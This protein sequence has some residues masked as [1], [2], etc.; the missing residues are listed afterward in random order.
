[1]ARERFYQ[2]GFTFAL[3][4]LLV[5]TGTLGSE[6]QAISSQSSEI[7]AFQPITDIP[8]IDLSDPHRFSLGGNPWYPIGYYPSVAALTIDQTDYE[9]YYKNLIDLLAANGLNYFRNVFTM[10]QPYAEAMAPYVRTGPGTAADGRAKF[11][12]GQFN[13]AYF[14]YWRNVATYAQSKGVVVQLTIFDNWHNKA[15]VVEDNGDSQHE[16]G[17]K[18]DFYSGAN[19]V[20]GVDT[21]NLGDWTNPAHAVYPV[22]Q[23]LIRKVVDELGDLPNIVYEISNENYASASW[24]LQLADYLSDYEASKGYGSHLVMPR[25]LPNHDAAGGKGNDPSTTHSEMVSRYGRNQP[26]IADNDGGGNVSADGRRNKAWAALTAGGHIDYF[27][28]A[29]YQ[30]SVLN[31]ADVANGMRYL[32]L[33]GS[34]LDTYQVELRGMVPSDSLVSAGW[35]YAAAGDRYIVYLISGGSTTISGLPGSYSAIW[36]DPRTGISSPAAGGP[37][38]TAP[39]SQDWVLYVWAS[40]ATPM[41]TVTATATQTDTPVPTATP[42]ASH[43]PAPTQTNTQTP[44]PTN[45]PTATPSETPTPLP[46]RTLTPLPTSTQVPSPTAVPTDTPT[47][48]LTRT[49]TAIPTNTPTATASLTPTSLPTKTPTATSTPTI[50]PT[51]TATAT[52]APIPGDINLDGRVDVLDAQICVNVFLG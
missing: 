39:D 13:Q 4:F 37:T 29:M 18:Y 52:P 51:E 10:G 50:Q 23:A 49:P 12:L 45:M 28:W 8:Q 27:H 40:A 43:T 5:G 41:S 25:D 19:N 9:N 38:F 31:S 44:L 47:A 34:F 42:T 1:M 11:D 36:Y 35:S 7:P 22:Q 46:S 2:G 30:T 24:E 26:L 6:F 15:W 17:M 3:A 21:A 16:W 32:G 48:T 33:V 14:D 20:N